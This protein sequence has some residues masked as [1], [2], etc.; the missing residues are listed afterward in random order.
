MKKIFILMLTA[1][2]LLCSC[3]KNKLPQMKYEDGNLI[4]KDGAVYHAAPAGYEPV[5]V[6]EAC[7]YFGDTDTTLYKIGTLDPA[8][9]MTEEYFGEATT[10]FYSD[11]ITLPTLAEMNPDTLYVCQATDTGSVSLLTIDD[12]DFIDMAVS[13]A[14][15]DGDQH[16][17][18][19]RN[20]QL[21]LDLKFY[22]ESYPAFYYNIS[23]A[24]LS[25]G[26]YVYNRNS[27]KGCVY[28]G[29]IFDEYL[30]SLYIQED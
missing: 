19:P 15:A 23:V 7:A 22:S 14:T 28:V 18:P 9:W 13:A 1:A 24:C 10:I 26:Y 6:G 3:G 5:S 11:S 4:S 2:L 25:D 17:W 30:K 16:I 12:K 29:T 27:G 20:T 21:N 8:I